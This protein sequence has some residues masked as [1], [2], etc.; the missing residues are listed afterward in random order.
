MDWVPVVE[1]LAGREWLGWITV[2]DA[3]VF[4]GSF[5][6][7][8]S[9]VMCREVIAAPGALLEPDLALEAAYGR[10]RKAG[11]RRLPVVQDGRL[12]GIVALP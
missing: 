4:L 3:A 8:P 2:H 7:R 5:D 6:K 12:V 11:M 10:I 1:T 9:E